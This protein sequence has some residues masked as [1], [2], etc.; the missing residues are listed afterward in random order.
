MHRKLFP[1]ACVLALGM[2]GPVA[3]QKERSKA[4]SGAPRA[5]AKS[6]ED[7]A[8]EKPAVGDQL[9]ELTVFSPDG[10]EFKTADL[11]GHY[12]VLTFGCLT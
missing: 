5:K 8:K 11:R 12:T 2:A 7:F 6:D 9:P 1:A 4:P 10:K 3:A